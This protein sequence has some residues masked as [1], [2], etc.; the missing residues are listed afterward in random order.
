MASFENRIFTSLE[1]E[2]R[3]TCHTYSYERSRTYILVMRDFE[4][5]CDYYYYYGKC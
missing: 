5:F 2:R 1:T 4:Y 3:L